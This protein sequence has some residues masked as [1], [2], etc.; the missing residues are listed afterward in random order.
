MEPSGQTV[1]LGR[2]TQIEPPMKLSEGDVL[3][4]AGEAHARGERLQLRARDLTGLGLFRADLHAVD[5][6]GSDMT[7]INLSHADLRAADLTQATLTQAGFF[8]ANLAGACLRHADLTFSDFFQ[9]NL[10][11]ADLTGAH[12]DHANLEGANLDGVTLAG[13]T[14]TDDT[15]WPLDFDPKATGA[16]HRI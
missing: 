3:Q 11:G 14:Y 13:A 8:R 7:E 10:A 2:P 15:R 1:L 12:L 6:C 4:L 5:F 9:A 16:R